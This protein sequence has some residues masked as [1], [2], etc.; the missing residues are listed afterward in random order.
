MSLE[1]GDLVRIVATPEGLDAETAPV[2]EACIGRVFRVEGFDQGLV[3][4]LV[5]EAFG[6]AP[7]LRSIWIEHELLEVVGSQQATDTR[8]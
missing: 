6:E 3:E 1:V 7:Y 4:L 2:F 5:G 8:D